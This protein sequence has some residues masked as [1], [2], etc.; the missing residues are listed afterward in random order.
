MSE[1]TYGR[2]DQVL[3]SL[4]FAV[5]IAEGARVYK[6]EP[7]GALIVVPLAAE[8]DKVLPHHLQTVRWTLD[9]FGI[10]SPLMF[11]EQLQKAS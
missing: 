8:A 3:R 10:A 1:P 11:A 5:R 2:L 9:Q 7:S 4:R 6:H